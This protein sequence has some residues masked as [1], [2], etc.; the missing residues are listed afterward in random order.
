M[1]RA[2]EEMI[3]ENEETARAAGLTY[4]DDT[5]PGIT[6]ARRGRGFA[7]T[8]HT[9]K[10]VDDEQTLARIRALAVPPAWTAVWICASPRGHLQATGRDAKGRKQYRYHAR[11]RDV[12]DET[13][14]HRM[15]AFGAVLPK[16]RKRAD[17]DLRKEGL[18]QEKVVAA[19]VRLLDRT[20]ARVGNT[21]YARENGSYGITTL[22]DD[23][24]KV[25]GSTIALAFTGKSGKTH[26]LRLDDA[27]LAKIVRRCQDLPGQQ[28][29][30]YLDD[31]GELRALG[32]SDV[33]DYIRE[34][35]GDDFTAK[36]FRTWAGTVLFAR[37]CKEI[38]E[39]ETARGR[40]RNTTLAFDAVARMLG[41]TKAVCKASYVHP[42]LADS[43]GCGE[44]QRLWDA[45]AKARRT[46]LRRDEAIVLSMLRRLTKPSAKAAA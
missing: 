25:R 10:K 14:F 35:T 8:D 26:E 16:I 44:F 40:T 7:Y 13:K 32:S 18:P 27:R 9:G 15:A 36:D 21:A 43:Y 30:Q 41:N 2:L 6:R 23:H 42:A 45:S 46:G 28:L 38:G 5:Q 37:A 34:I 31:D 20:L 4:V 22:R 24:V 17:G 11:W 39:A 3:A 1:A 33:N 29:F 12:R 19:A